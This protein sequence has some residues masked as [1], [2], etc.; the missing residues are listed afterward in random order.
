MELENWKEQV[1]NE[2]N[3]KMES[4]FQRMKSINEENQKQFSSIETELVDAKVENQAL[5]T[6]IETLK[7]GKLNSIYYIFKTCL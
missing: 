2:I 6:E 1:M 7:E 5:K 3:A 4:E